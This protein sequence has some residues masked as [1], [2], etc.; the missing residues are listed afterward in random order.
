MI[1]TAYLTPAIFAIKSTSV[2]WLFSRFPA[3]VKEMGRTA[4]KAA[5]SLKKHEKQKREDKKV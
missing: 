5:K 3:I 4:L 2:Q 1:E